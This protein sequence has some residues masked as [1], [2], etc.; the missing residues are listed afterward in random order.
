[1][2][3]VSISVSLWLHGVVGGACIGI[4]TTR[5]RLRVKGFFVGR[6]SRKLIVSGVS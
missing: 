1:M 2:V 3:V 6:T 5:L 4:G